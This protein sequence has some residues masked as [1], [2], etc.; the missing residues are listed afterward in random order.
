MLK[1]VTDNRGGG[2]RAEGAESLH[3]C[4]PPPIQVDVLAKIYSLRAWHSSTII[5]S[6][7][8]SERFLTLDKE[9]KV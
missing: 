4:P 9:K 3:S 1:S 5:M 8:A 6:A 2:G 7:S